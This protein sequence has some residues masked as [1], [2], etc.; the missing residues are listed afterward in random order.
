MPSSKSQSPPSWQVI[1]N[2]LKSLTQF[3]GFEVKQT[4]S[5]AS[6]PVVCSEPYDRS[7]YVPGSSTYSL[8]KLG[9]YL[10][11]LQVSH[12]ATSTI[13]QSEPVSNTTVT[14]CLKALEPNHN[15]PVYIML[16]Q[17]YCSFLIDDSLCVV[18]LFF[19]SSLSENPFSPKSALSS[20]SLNN[21]NVQSHSASQKGCPTRD[22]PSQAIP[23]TIFMTESPLHAN[24]NAMF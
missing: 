3:Q 11:Y 20:F 18:F 9:S 23:W 4:V 24:R 19:S 13:S 16:S 7:P 22:V 8:E 14:S 21:L 10:F 5:R 1:A 6:Y 2:H 17:L 15:V 12:S